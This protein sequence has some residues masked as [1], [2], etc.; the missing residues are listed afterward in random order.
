VAHSAQRECRRHQPGTHRRALAEPP[1]GP[2]DAPGRA[3]R[4]CAKLLARLRLRPAAA[5]A[6]AVRLAEATTPAL[7]A[8]EARQPAPAAPARPQASLQPSRPA[9]PAQPGQPWCR[10]RRRLAPRRSMQRRRSAAAQPA[11]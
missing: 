11:W 5:R 7:E 9:H 4:A 2:P 6:A 3:L 1:R 8:A 10:S